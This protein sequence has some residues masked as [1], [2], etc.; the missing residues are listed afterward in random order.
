MCNHLCVAAAD[1][2]LQ[3]NFIKI[4]QVNVN[5]NG[6]AGETGKK[7]VCTKLLPGFCQNVS[8]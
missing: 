3:L 8:L 4:I 5:K 2:V 1:A 6:S 7:P